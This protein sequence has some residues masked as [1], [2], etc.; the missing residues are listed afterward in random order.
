MLPYQSR[1]ATGIAW[2][3]LPRFSISLSLNI[4]LTVVIAVRFVLHAKNTRTA[5]GIPGISGLCKAIDVMPIESCAIYAVS[6]FLLVG[7]L[8]AGSPVSNLFTPTFIE[9]QVGAFPEPR[10]LNDER[11]GDLS[12][13]P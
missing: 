4:I 11:S 10:S 6:S 8:G 9:A 13:P 3:A 5:L 7:T 12:S 1:K 2:S